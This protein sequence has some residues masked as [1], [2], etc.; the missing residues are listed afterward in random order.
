MND[1]MTRW[2]NLARQDLRM[3]ELALKEGLWNQVCLHSQQCVEKVLRALLVGRGNVPPH[4]HKLADLIF[5][6]GEEA[7][8]GLADD[9][10]SLDRFYI[11]THYPDTLPG[12]L[13]ESLPS[14]EDAR[15]ALVLARRIIISF[16][17]GLP[18]DGPP[19]LTQEQP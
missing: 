7:I 19:S 1:Q 9:L 6:L 2:L 11:P 14:E 17:D 16:I 4:T 3:A 12:S 13:S 18:I 8:S 15:E 5:L 10:Y